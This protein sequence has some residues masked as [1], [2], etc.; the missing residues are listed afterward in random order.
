MEF[1]SPIV[2]DTMINGVSGAMASLILNAVSTLNENCN[3]T[4]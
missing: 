2:P 1:S 3:H 4:I